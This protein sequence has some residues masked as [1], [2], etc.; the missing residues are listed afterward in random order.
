MSLKIVDLSFIDKENGFYVKYGK[1]GLIRGI[2]RD[3]IIIE[4]DVPWQ[5]R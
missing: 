5:I 1:I 3:Y 2:H 4:V